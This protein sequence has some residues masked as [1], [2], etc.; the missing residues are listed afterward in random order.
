MRML[1]ENL[2][3]TTGSHNSKE[4]SSRFTWRSFRSIG[5]NRET[6]DRREPTSTRTR[7][8]LVIGAKNMMTFTEKVD[9][10]LWPR[11]MLAK[12]HHARLSLEPPSSHI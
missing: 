3:K 2:L 10:Y 6:L 5:H 4:S 11:G 12:P 9:K 8:N 7:S 1:R